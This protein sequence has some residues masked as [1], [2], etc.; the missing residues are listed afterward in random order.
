MVAV[1]V[2][3]G[4]AAEANLHVDHAAAA[5]VRAGD[6]AVL[7][8]DVDAVGVGDGVAEEVGLGLLRAAAPS[9]PSEDMARF[10]SASSALEEDGSSAAGLAAAAAARDRR[11]PAPR[12]GDRAPGRGRALP[13]RRRQD[14]EIRLVLECSCDVSLGPIS[15]LRELLISSVYG[16]ATPRRAVAVLCVRARDAAHWSARSGD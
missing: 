12:A 16:N 1:G 9:E 13:E 3:F 15:G 2:V 6:G 14:Q 11:R 7:R 8:G 5:L 10:N 4:G